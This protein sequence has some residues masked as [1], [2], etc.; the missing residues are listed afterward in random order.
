MDLV[1]NFFYDATIKSDKIL[2]PRFNFW[3]DMIWKNIA[4][5]TSSV[6][7][8]VVICIVIIQTGI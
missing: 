6:I 3:N 2:Q 7:Y 4:F 1:S 5:K 8:G